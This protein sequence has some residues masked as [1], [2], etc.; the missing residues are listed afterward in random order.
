MRWSNAAEAPPLRSCRDRVPGS[1]P[2]PADD[3]WVSRRDAGAEP[4]I[5]PV[6]GAG[7]PAIR[8]AT[9]I[10]SEC[11]HDGET[12]SP[13]SFPGQVQRSHDAPAVL[14]LVPAALAK[15]EP[16][17]SV[18]RLEAVGSVSHGVRN[19][20]CNRLRHCGY[21]GVSWK[22]RPAGTMRA[23]H[24]TLSR[25]PLLVGD[26]SGRDGWNGGD[27]NHRRRRSCLTTT[28]NH[29][30]PEGRARPDY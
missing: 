16:R 25:E 9:A 8:P 19:F 28:N 11:E 14:G 2:P 23:R 29:L 7:A 1:A 18:A 6:T 17:P 21:R 4:S 10:T 15:Y 20:D 30:H 22:T 5:A 3:D 27:N 26:N 24:P 12:Q 13:R